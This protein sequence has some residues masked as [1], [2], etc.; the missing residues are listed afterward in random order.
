MLYHFQY[1]FSISIP[2]TFHNPFSKNS[3]ENIKINTRLK[4]RCDKNWIF[5]QI[6]FKSSKLQCLSRTDNY[7][8]GVYINLCEVLVIINYPKKVLKKENTALK[9][10]HRCFE[11]L[12]P[13]IKLF[14][15]TKHQ[16][17]G[18]KKKKTVV[19]SFSLF[20]ISI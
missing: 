14:I 13:N 2:N 12:M 5:L 19:L 20:H 18:S 7:Q 3:S 6:F 1:D 9:K 15:M 17:D 16:H 4:K 11:E 10:Y 8:K